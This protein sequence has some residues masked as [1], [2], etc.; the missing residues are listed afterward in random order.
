V[1]F[2]DDSRATG[3]AGCNHFTATYSLGSSNLRLSAIAMTRMYCVETMELEGRYVSALESTRTYRV[4][5]SRLEL[6]NDRD[7]V[8]ALFEKR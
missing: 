4:T 5:G 1:L 2:G 8:V 6:L 7:I 3:F